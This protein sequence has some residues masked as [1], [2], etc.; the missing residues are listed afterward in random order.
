[1]IWKIVLQILNVLVAVLIA[2]LDYLWHDK[3]TLKFKKTRFYLYIALS[4]LLGTNIYVTITDD[5]NNKREIAVRDIKI[6]E[7]TAK[8][9]DIKDEL[10]SGDSFC[11]LDFHTY[12][13]TSK[14]EARHDNEITVMLHHEGKHPLYDIQIRILDPQRINKVMSEHFK[15]PM[16][17]E[18][19]EA[20]IQQN[21][22]VDR[23][24][25]GFA[26]FIDKWVF[27]EKVDKYDMNIEFVARNGSWK[28]DMR[29]IRQKNGTWGAAVRT[30]RKEKVLVER[31]GESLPKDDSGKPKWN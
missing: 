9:E 30:T 28:Q 31:G 21:Y 8:V 6:T 12:M 14:D 19:L 26:K 15:S 13:Y 4:I 1:M 10:I 27:P 3:R 2:N 22:H 5:R 18:K 7:L 23:L 11:Y 16:P 29:F 24:N 20:E 25:S 17:F